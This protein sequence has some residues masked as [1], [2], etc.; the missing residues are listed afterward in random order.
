MRGVAH[1]SVH[2]A[3]Y[4][5]RILGHV[6]GLHALG[7]RPAALRS[8][9]PAYALRATNARLAS[10]RARN[11]STVS[12]VR[13]PARPGHDR[14]RLR[15]AIQPQSFRT[16]S[17]ERRDR[18]TN[19]QSRQRG[20]TAI[21]CLR[22]RRVRSRA[23]AAAS[24]RWPQH[25]LETAYLHRRQED[26]ATRLCNERHLRWGSLGQ[27]LDD[28]LGDESVELEGL[29][30]L[31]PGAGLGDGTTLTCAPISSTAKDGTSR[32]AV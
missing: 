20:E 22:H 30:S 13:S 12:R 5:Q 28:T 7:A 32:G 27:D 16:L 3:V 2:N 21:A 4:P 15:P 19:M 1:S 26:S 29:R 9:W 14:R 11:P 10:A 25:Q 24:P 6:G 17:R 8:T 18:G 23:R 31:E